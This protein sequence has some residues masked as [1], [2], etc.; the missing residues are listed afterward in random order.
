M[1]DAA[2]TTSTI[3]T[4]S[5]SRWPRSDSRRA[6]NCPSHESRPADTDQDWLGDVARLMTMETAPDGSDCAPLTG[7]PRHPARSA[8]CDRGEQGDDRLISAAPTAGSV[9]CTTYRGVGRASG[10]TG[11]ARR[12]LSVAGADLDVRSP[13]RASY[14]YLVR[15]RNVCGTRLRLTSGSAPRAAPVREPASR[16]DCGAGNHGCRS[17]PTRT[18]AAVSMRDVPPGRA[19]SPSSS[20]SSPPKPVKPGRCQ[21]DRV[22][23]GTRVTILLIRH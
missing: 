4:A 14:W 8:A 5:S 11:P 23:D 22:V 20:S 2:S 18:A 13:L 9:Q 1:P 17:T 10:R 21:D 12:W 3:R 6:D 16:P 7:L 19:A 15:G